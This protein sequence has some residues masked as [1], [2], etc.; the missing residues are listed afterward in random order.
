MEPSITSRAGSGEVAS[1]VERNR[2]QN[3]RGGM[4]EAARFG[5]GFS[6]RKR[7]R[8]KREKA[9]ERQRKKANIRARRFAIA[10]GEG[11]KRVRSRDAHN[12]ATKTGTTKTTKGG[13]ELLRKH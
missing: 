9:D 2:V 1:R 11:G 4:R 13:R 12:A 7:S 10:G 6:P 5:E 8:I 3:E